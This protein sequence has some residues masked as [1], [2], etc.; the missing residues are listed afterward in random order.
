[1]IRHQVFIQFIYE[2]FPPSNERHVNNKVYQRPQISL[3]IFT[4]SLLP[5]QMLNTFKVV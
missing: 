2:G 4:F 1:M 5:M 3:I